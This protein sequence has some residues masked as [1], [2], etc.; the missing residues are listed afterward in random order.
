MQRL[1][2]ECVLV[3][4]PR[5]ERVTVKCEGC[6][7]AIERYERDVARNLTGRF[8]CSRECQHRIGV[9]PR[10]GSE[11]ACEVCGASF[12]AMPREAR[13]FCSRTCAIAWQARNA[14]TFDCEVCGTHVRLSP[15]Q[16]RFRLGG[17][18]CSRKCMG[19]AHLA[20]P[21][22][23]M[24]NGRPAKLSTTGY[25][26]VYEPDHPRADRG[27]WVF[28]HR[29]VVEARIGRYLEPE[30]NVHHLNGVKDDNRSENLVVLGH[31]EHL[32]LTG[33]NHRN[34]LAAM[35]AELD[36]YRRLY[37]PLPATTEGA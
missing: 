35:Q 4:R 29:L 26:Q 20:R 12:Y 36:E 28:E 21:L 25:V 7:K 31:T 8:F 19:D 2:R 11:R 33:R 13:R 24:H 15:S 30:E 10:R 37:G 34:Q 18:F 16:H 14:Q 9:K 27:G 23:R 3:G 5:N 6:G 1:P 17:R 22:D 32:V